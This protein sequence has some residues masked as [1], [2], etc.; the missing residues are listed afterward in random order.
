MPRD[1]A[2]RLIATLAHPLN[3]PQFDPARRRVVNGYT[4]L[5]PRI[6][7][8]LP[9]ARRSRF[10]RLVAGSLAVGILLVS[11]VFRLFSHRGKK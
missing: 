4:I 9:A 1:T 10:T 2:R 11:T 7:F 6:G 3:L 5:Q 8:S